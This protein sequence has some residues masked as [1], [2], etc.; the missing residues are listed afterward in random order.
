MMG[1]FIFVSDND[2]NV[3]AQTSLVDPPDDLHRGIIEKGCL[4]QR[5]I[6]EK[7][8]RL[9]EETFYTRKASELTPYDRGSYPCLLYTSR[10][11]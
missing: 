8:F 11:V 4:T 5:T 6:D 3:I 9:P 10:C 2:F 7:R 1:N